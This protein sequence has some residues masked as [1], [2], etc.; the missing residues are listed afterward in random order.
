M[1]ENS[2][3]AHSDAYLE[4]YVRPE[5][6]SGDLQLVA[7]S[8]GVKVAASIAVNCAGLNLYISGRSLNAA[9]IRWAQEQL[10]AGKSRKDV[11][12]RLGVSERWLAANAASESTQLELWDE[13]DL[14]DDEMEE[15]Q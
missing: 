11:A 7:R 2:N 6:L 8:L 15:K 5:D 9:R 4:D 13:D 14:T 10:K 3:A 12:S 1:A